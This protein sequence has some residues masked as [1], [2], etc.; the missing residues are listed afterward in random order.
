[1]SGGNYKIEVKIENIIYN[2]YYATMATYTKDEIALAM[3]SGNLVKKHY[4]GINNVKCT[5]GSYVKLPHNL[6][7]ATY[8][9]A[10]AYLK[11][12][13]QREHGKRGAKMPIIAAD[14]FKR[15]DKMRDKL[16]R[17]LAKRCPSK[18]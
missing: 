12:I 18:K 13:H 11:A 8:K 7:K 4:S 2:T 6:D 17:K 5:G 14:A 1:M 10:Q 9:I 3:I 15:S 16:R